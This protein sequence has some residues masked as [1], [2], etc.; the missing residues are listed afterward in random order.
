MGAESAAARPWALV[1]GASSGMGRVFARELAGRGMNVVLVARS[2]DKLEALAG[3]LRARHGA[4]ALVVARD[5]AEPG[6]A[7]RVGEAVDAAGVEVEVLVNNAGIGKFGRDV[8]IAAEYGRD[9]VML[10]VVA[11]TGLVKRFM[12]GMVARGSGS[13]V[14]VASMAGFQAQPYMAL[15]AAT[16]AFVVNY[17]LGLWE[18][19]R[20]T[21]VR[22]LAVC[23]GPVDTG[24]PIA[25]GIKYN[26][27]K[28]GWLLAEPEQIVRQSLRALDRNRGY[29]VPDAK[30]W[31]EAH[32]LPRRPRRLMTRLIGLVLRRFADYQDR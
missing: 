22:V 27:R 10:N 21:G 23:P 9:A 8:E 31:P 3:E 19:A 30:N 7:E 2:A 24:F 26:R 12:P 6:A 5:L 28:L 32:L 14:N 1:T 29:T 11:V 20:G 13:V 16:K 25:N 17:S 4:E 18:E 15:Y